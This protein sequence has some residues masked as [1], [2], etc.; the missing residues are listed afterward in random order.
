M[1]A[2]PEKLSKFSVNEFCEKTGDASSKFMSPLILD[3]LR[4]PFH[5][6]RE[7]RLL[8][9]QAHDLSLT[10]KKKLLYMMIDENE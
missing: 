9:N 7:M 5:D 6:P 2:K 1:I 10:D 8:G 4:Y 3:E